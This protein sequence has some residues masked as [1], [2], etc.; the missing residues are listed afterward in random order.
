MS[1]LAS[2]RLLVKVIRNHV[3]FS[4]ISKALGRP[5]AWV[6]SGSPVEI[7]LAANVIPFYPENHSAICSARSMAESLSAVAEQARYSRDLCSYFRIDF[8][9]ATTG[10]T[11]LKKMLKPDI[12]VAC[13]NICGT[14]QNWFAIIAE[15]F[16]VPFIMIDTPF[17]D[18]PTTEADV[19][20]VEL[21]L[22][23]LA[24]D[25]QRFLG[26]RVDERRLVSVVNLSREALMLWRDIRQTAAQRPAP[27][28][29]FDAFVHM[30]P[31]VSMRG[32]GRAI[33]YYKRLLH[34]LRQRQAAGVAA[35]PNERLRVIWDN[36]AIWP[37]H[38]ELKRFFREHGVA[39]VAD[40]YT[41]AWSSSSLDENDPYHGLA[42]SYCDIILNHGMSYRVNLL[43]SMIKEYNADGF[44]LHSNRSCKRYS[45]CQYVV[46]RLVTERTG[47]PG[48]I[49]EADMADPRSVS[50]QA[51][52][53]RLSPFFEMLRATM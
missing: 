46:R 20:Y 7:L 22:R 28:T 39:L 45:L 42:R 30:V 17:S 32:T 47:V 38:R 12:V 9:H 43:S 52:T 11:P 5:V 6:T 27:F 26:R 37:V 49:I 21:Q 44:I 50:L 10:V 23:Q 18:G 53:G 33:S 25:L 31:I 35:V 13:N 19:S 16:N 41:G 40:T 1:T 51:I 4:R 15:Y 36:I 29:S 24:N 8:G 2:N 3:L 48:V 14:V 34:E